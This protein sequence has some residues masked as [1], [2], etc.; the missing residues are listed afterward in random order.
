MNALERMLDE[1][2]T[3]QIGA[4]PQTPEVNGQD[5]VAAVRHL[6]LGLGL[7]GIHINLKRLC[8][9]LVRTTGMQ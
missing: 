9:G 7:G 3:R 5:E 2:L 6:G 1:P 8:A 4:L